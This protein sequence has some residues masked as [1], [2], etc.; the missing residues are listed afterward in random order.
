ME[1]QKSK[2]HQI[3]IELDDNVGQGEYVNLA[4]VTHSP[5]EFVMDFIR[6][7]G[8]QLSVKW[9]IGNP[10][11]GLSRSCSSGT[12]TFTG[13]VTVQNNNDWQ[14]AGTY[15][16]YYLRIDD[17]YTN[18]HRYYWENGNVEGSDDLDSTHSFNFA[19]VTL[20]SGL[21]GY[22]PSFLDGKQLFQKDT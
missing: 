11:P 3:K 9:N 12:C 20:V 15:E 5:A 14:Y 22:A 1:K 17:K 8:G 6:P 18:K 10:D 16:F 2:Q 7:I 19:D 13:S 4:I 21:P